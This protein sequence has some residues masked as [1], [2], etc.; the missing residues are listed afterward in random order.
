MNLF[1][2]HSIVRKHIF[3]HVYYYLDTKSKGVIS[4]E[5]RRN[6]YDPLN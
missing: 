3:Q 4:G 1:D 5:K 6:Q 2:K